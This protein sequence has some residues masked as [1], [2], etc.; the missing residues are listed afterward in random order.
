MAVY[1]GNHQM[2]NSDTDIQ[3]TVFR[4][5]ICLDTYFMP[6]FMVFKYWLID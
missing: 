1:I 4:L 5:N 2:I 6:D 3:K